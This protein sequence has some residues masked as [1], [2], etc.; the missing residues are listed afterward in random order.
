MRQPV[1]ADD[2][3]VMLG[4][5]MLRDAARMLELVELRLVE[6]DRERLHRRLDASAISPT[7]TLESTP[8]ER[9]AP[10][11]TSLTMCDSDGIGQHGLER[12][13]GVFA[14]PAERFRAADLPVPLRRRRGRPASVR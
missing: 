8:P 10:S 2:E 12:A 6:A 7:T 14:G 5:E 4:A 1:R 11:G 3:L 13:R 9:K